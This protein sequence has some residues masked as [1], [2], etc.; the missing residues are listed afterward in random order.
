V[1]EV[2]VVP[3]VVPNPLVEL[4]NPPVELPNPPVVPPVP[5]VPP[6]PCALATD[7]I[8]RRIKDVATSRSG[9]N[10]VISLLISVG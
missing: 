3:D 10:M 9:V 7:A 6:V 4:P 1:P 5:P 2:P 8:E